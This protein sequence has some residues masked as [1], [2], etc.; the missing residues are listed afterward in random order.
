MNLIGKPAPEFTA[1]AIVDGQVVRDFSL[2]SYRDRYVVL[3]FYPE[4]FT[5]VCGSEVHAFQ[6][7]LAAPRAE[8]KRWTVLCFFASVPSPKFL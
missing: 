1:T 4:D 2:A 8:S 3:F 7:R 6:A 5:G